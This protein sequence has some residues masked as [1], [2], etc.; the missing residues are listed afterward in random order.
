ME[1]SAA[2]EVDDDYDSV[3]VDAY[4]YLENMQPVDDREPVQQ[5]REEE[6][7]PASC[8]ATGL[9]AEWLELF[10]RLGLAGM[11]ASIAAN[12]SL[13]AVDGDRWH[14]HLDPG[15]SA[16][17]NAGQQR[18]LTDALSSYHGR[19]LTLQIDI[20]RP[21]QETPAQAAARQRAERQR[22][23]EASIH[24]DPLVR[25]MMEQFAAVIRDGTIV[26]LDN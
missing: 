15:Q 3:D 13:V 10:P 23:A 16:L 6:P 1:E 5:V 8:P 2:E 21:E 9:A 24:A 20:V 7:L 18:R 22:A 19:P 11:T 12:C 14:L 4:A 25:Q 26:P 17:F